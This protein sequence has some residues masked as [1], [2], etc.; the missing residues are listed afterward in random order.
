MSRGTVVLLHGLARTH[1]SLGW[2]G[3]RLEERGY[4]TWAVSY[5]SRRGTL[6][7]L[8]E[9]LAA[10]IREELGG[11]RPLHAVTHSLGGVLVRHMQAAVGFDRVVMLAP[12]NRGSRLA[13]AVRHLPLYRALYG[14]AGHEVTEPD[15]WPPAPASCGV[16]AG[17]R[18]RSPGNPTSWLAA[19]LR[20]LPPGEPAD[21]T[22]LVEETRLPGLADFTTVDASHTWILRHAAV[23]A[24]CEAFLEHGR[25]GA[26]PG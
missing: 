8:S 13:L 26:V 11:R 25:F 19:A 18:R 1:R 10:R 5:P 15:A 12:P 14:P 6:A 3:A 16:I 7:Q 17:T 22:L 24:L 21:G 2:L 4:S 9:A 23:P 20:L